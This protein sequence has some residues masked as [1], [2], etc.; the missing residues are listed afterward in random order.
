MNTYEDKTYYILL[1]VLQFSSYDTV[2]IIYIIYGFSPENMKALTKNFLHTK[3][4][5]LS[6][7]IL[8]IANMT[9]PKYFTWEGQDLDGLN[10][11]L[12]F[13][14]LGWHHTEVQPQG[15]LEADNS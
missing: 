12:C 5:M 11:V 7:S 1:S 8:K 6:L 4:E 13:Y 10:V 3:K 2:L 15:V 14:I 9:E